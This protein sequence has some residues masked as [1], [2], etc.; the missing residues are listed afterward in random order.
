MALEVDP[1]FWP[2]SLELERGPLSR[3][4]SAEG[5]RYCLGNSATSLA[6]ASCLHRQ[7]GGVFPI[8]KR[9]QIGY[10]SHAAPRGLR[11]EVQ[12]LEKKL[13]SPPR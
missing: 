7:P 12:V 1:T 11:Q 6:R 3:A 13:L 8:P 4:L 9:A 5:G 10:K 2:A